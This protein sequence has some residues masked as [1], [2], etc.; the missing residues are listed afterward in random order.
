MA[1]TRFSGF[2]VDWTTKATV[3]SGQ[4]TNFKTWLNTRTT[5]LL[6]WLTNTFLA[7]LEQTTDGDSGADN[8]GM[9]K[10]TN[11]GSA[12]AATI[13]AQAEALDTALSTHSAETVY[14]RKTATRDGQTT[15]TQS[16]T[17][18][19]GLPKRIEIRAAVAGTHSF[20]LGS[21]EQTGGQGSTYQYV[22]NTMALGG[23]SAIMAY[24]DSGNGLA[25]TI[26]NVANGSFDISWA[27]DGAGRVGTISLQIICSYH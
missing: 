5:D 22:A 3:I 23:S 21:Y 9:T 15:G 27:I 10:L 11:Y 4:A 7:E 18:L 24:T 16:I 25:G 17:G 8:V 12:A 6:I 14:E 2:T 13:Q 26:Q 19:A 20:S 1:F